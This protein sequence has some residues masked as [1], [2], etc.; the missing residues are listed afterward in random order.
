MMIQKNIGSS[1]NNP[2]MC[3]FFLYCWNETFL[4]KPMGSYFIFYF[5]FFKKLTLLMCLCAVF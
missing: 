5:Y 3:Y 2:N 1:Q 4:P